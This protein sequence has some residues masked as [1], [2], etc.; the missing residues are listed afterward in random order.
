VGNDLL[1][2]VL[3][4]PTIMLMERY[5]DDHPVDALFGAIKSGDGDVA[6]LLTRSLE[7]IGDS[8]IIPDCFAVIREYCGFASQALEEL[9]DCPPRRSLSDMVDYIRERSR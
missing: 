9:P 8:G 4:L 5:P 6:S 1:Q 3:T 7:M 2:G